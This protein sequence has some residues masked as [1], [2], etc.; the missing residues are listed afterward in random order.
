MGMNV[1]V[2]TPIDYR[3]DAG[4]FVIELFTVVVLLIQY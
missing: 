3:P 2:A 1:R 4:I